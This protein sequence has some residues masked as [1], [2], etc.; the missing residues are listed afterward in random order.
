MPR[1]VLSRRLLSE[2]CSSEAQHWSSLTRCSVVGVALTVP[3]S[4]ASADPK[5]FQALGGA[6]KAEVNIPSPTVRRNVPFVSSLQDCLQYP[7][8]TISVQADALE[9]ITTLQR[10]TQICGSSPKMLLLS[11]VR[12]KGKGLILP[13]GSW[14]T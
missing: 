1:A 13:D 11:A 4:V 8:S 2:S 10:H 7:F 12:H 14:T 5:L 6:L 9:F 3:S